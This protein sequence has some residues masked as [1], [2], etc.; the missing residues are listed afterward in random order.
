MPTYLRDLILLVVNVFN[1][2]II[3]Y[4]IVGNGIYTFLVAVS[5]VSVW[6]YQ[7]RIGYAGLQEVRESVVTPP[8]AVIVPAFNEQDCILLSVESLLNLDYPAKEIIVVD[9]G[10][11]DDTLLRLIERFQL[12]QMDLIYRPKLPAKMP[13]RFFH[14]PEL[15]QLTVVSKVN[16]GKPDAL[17]VGINIARSPYVCTVDADSIIE[18]DALL[19]LMYPV[20]RSPINTV[21]SAGIVRI[22]N[23]CKVENG[24]VTEIQLPKRAVEKFQVVEYLRGFL[25]GQG[26]ERAGSHL[27]GLRRLLHLPP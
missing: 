17:N 12:T 2:V 8:V 21:V 10:S 20:I 19:R 11:T 7:K 9:D 25:F 27:R 3:L 13:E 15:P 14:N 26:L 4:F 5:F 22:V 23:G 16:G 1:N 18:K 24:Q 6:I